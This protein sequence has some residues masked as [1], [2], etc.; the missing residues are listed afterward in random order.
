MAGG[1]AFRADLPRHAQKRLE[2]HIG[3]AMGARDRG[4]ASQV[5][6]HKRTHDARL[7]LLLEVHDVMREIQMPRHGLCVVDIVERA[8]ASLYRLIGQA[9]MTREA[10]LIPELKRE[11]HDVVALLS[12][13]DTE[14]QRADLMALR[15]GAADKDHRHIRLA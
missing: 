8:A 1:E 13:D 7:E 2:L 10:A 3:I 4:A 15:W 14:Y 12:H 6:I 11:P 9:M 5:L